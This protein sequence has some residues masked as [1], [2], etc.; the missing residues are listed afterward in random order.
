M[1]A[2]GAT[3]TKSGLSQSFEKMVSRLL[4]AELCREDPGVEERRETR[5]D[6]AL[7]LSILVSAHFRICG[8][9]KRMSDHLVAASG[10]TGK[11]AVT[12]LDAFVVAA[13]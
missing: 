6:G 4:C 2:A 1:A 13:V 10:A 3:S 11:G 7:T 12:S 8:S 5:D 9:K